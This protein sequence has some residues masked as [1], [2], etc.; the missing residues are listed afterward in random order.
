MGKSGNLLSGKK[1][2]GFLANPLI[3]RSFDSPSSNNGNID[4]TIQYSSKCKEA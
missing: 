4:V 1:C 2:G 3:F